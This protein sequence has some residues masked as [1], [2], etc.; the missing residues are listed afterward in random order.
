MSYINEKGAFMHNI[1]P[2]VLCG[3]VGSRLWP[4]SRQSLPKQFV[5]LIDESSL[6]EEAVR[7]STTLGGMPPVIVTASDYRFLVRNQL[8][9]FDVEGHILLE[10]IAKT[11]CNWLQSSSL[12]QKQGVWHQSFWLLAYQLSSGTPGRT[13]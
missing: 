3:G 4:L 12:T 9:D 13:S 5:Q 1:V 7:R 6:F 11:Q 8:R 2:I 10:P